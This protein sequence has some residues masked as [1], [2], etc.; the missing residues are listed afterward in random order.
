MSEH[1]EL[2]ILVETEIRLDAEVASARKAADDARET[3]RAQ[4]RAAEARLDMDIELERARIAT[5]LAAEVDAQTRAIEA[6]AH[7]AV[8]HYDA[9]RGEPLDRL[10]SVLA[11]RLI[12]LLEEEP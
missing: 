2:A 6:R 11:R 12:A 9:L 10:A 8:Q 5:T 7:A 4:A 1:S 3:A